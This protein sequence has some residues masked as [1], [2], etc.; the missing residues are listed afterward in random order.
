M[1]LIPEVER[2]L[3]LTS[4]TTSGSWTLFTGGASN[5]KGSE[6]GLELARS[7]GDGVIEAK[8]DSLLIV[9]QANGTFEHVPRDQNSEANALANL[10]S[11]VDS[12]EFDSGEVVQLMNSVVEEGNA[13]RLTDSKGKW[14]EIFPEVL[15]AYH[16]T[17]KPSTGATPFSQVYGAEA[18]DEVEE[19]SLGF[20]YATEMSNNEAMTTSLDLLDER[21]EAALVQLATQK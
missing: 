15:W 14:K 6:L 1:A 21:R 8:C 19:S 4:G 10:G 13:K 7:L 20:Q 16:M 12:D 5:A 11:S 18:F 3:L 9:N 17:S 2:E